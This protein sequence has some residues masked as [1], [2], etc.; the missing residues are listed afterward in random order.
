[1]TACKKE[2]E[3]KNS[4]TTN[5]IDDVKKETKEWYPKLGIK[6]SIKNYKSPNI[7][8]LIVPSK[9]NYNFD[10]ANSVY[11]LNDN[12]VAYVF[13]SCINQ[14][15]FLIYKT[16]QETNLISEFIVCYENDIAYLKN[17]KG[18]IIFKYDIVKNKEADC[19]QLG[20]IR[21][22]ETVSQC[23]IRNYTNSP[24]DLEGATFIILFPKETFLACA[25]ICGVS[26]L[27]N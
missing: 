21:P 20:H 1:M 27:M 17:L 25:I 16:D 12:S 3:M 24:C 10:I 2:N 7:K 11:Y 18:E 26:A 22:K 19:N 4:L 5:S 14:D 23:I 6:Y 13:N 15:E 8:S 9:G